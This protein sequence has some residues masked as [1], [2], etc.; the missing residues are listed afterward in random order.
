M[1]TL[2]ILFYHHYLIILVEQILGILFPNVLSLNLFA[3]ACEAHVFL[4]REEKE[5]LITELYI[6]CGGQALERQSQGPEVYDGRGKRPSECT[7]F[8]CSLPVPS[9]L[10]F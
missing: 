9:G 2:H 8:L 7:L 3:D 6:L 10:P 4:L 1:N 5:D